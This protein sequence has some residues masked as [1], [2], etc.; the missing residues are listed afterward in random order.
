[1]LK[2]H[3]S[4]RRGFIALDRV[5]PLPLVA[6]AGHIDV[7]PIGNHHKAVPP[8]TH[9]SQIFPGIHLGIVHEKLALVWP[10]AGDVEA[11]AEE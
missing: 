10:A 1:M 2:V 9:G 11:I 3:P 6:A 5:E 8:L 4:I 7:P